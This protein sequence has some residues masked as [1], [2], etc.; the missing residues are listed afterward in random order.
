M[1]G[2][3]AM[4]IPQAPGP[5]SVQVVM[6]GTGM[7]RPDP[8]RSGPATAIVVNGAAYIVDAGPGVV[9]RAAAAAARGIAA[10]RAPNLKTVFITHLHSDHT[11]GYPDL[12]LTPWVV[13]RTEPLNAFGPKGL[14]RMT[15]HILEAYREDIDVR[16][17][18]LEHQ[19]P[20]GCQVNVHEIKPGVAYQDANVKV[21]AFLVK[22]GAWK[23]AFGYRFDTKDR[24]IV[25]SGDTRPC[26][27]LLQAA[28][29]VDVL[30]HEVYDSA[31]L[32]PENRPGGDEWPKYMRAYHTSAHELGQIAAKCRPKLLVL[33]HVVRRH[34][35]DAELIQE[36]R[37]GGFDGPVVVAKDLDVY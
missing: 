21:T 11:L 7:P 10:L 8:D 19:E 27:G 37:D 2:L 16:I 15:K 28:Q 23:Q 6:L 3:P 35:S 32:E 5:S 33:Y 18:D 1:I 29:G 34:D 24:S 30:V 20:E 14:Y 9:R 36:V 31:E 13:G 26:D 25:L 12:I 22:H 4:T 17:H